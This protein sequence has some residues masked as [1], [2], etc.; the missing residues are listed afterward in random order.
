MNPWKDLTK[1]KK[2]KKNP[3]KVTL[4]LFLPSLTCERNRLEAQ[5][6]WT[7]NGERVLDFCTKLTPVPLRV[8]LYSWHPKRKTRRTNGPNAQLAI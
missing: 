8:Q 1:K 5:K 7:F 2:K 4:G 3:S 6:F